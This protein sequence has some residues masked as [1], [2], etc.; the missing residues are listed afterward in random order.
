[1]QVST[2]WLALGGNKRGNWGEPRETFRRAL[3]ELGANGLDMVA[4][5]SLYLTPPVGNVRQS[6]F[7]NAVVEMRGSISPGSLLRLL[8]RLEREAGRRSGVRWGPRPLDLD[9]LDFGGRIV[10]R[11]SSRRAAGQILLPH[12]EMARRGFVLVPLAEIAPGWRHPLLG[13]PAATLL[14]RSPG[15]AKGIRLAAG[16]QWM[17]PRSGE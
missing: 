3:I 6:P 10:G 13:V 1:M 4:A 9:I 14:R 16:P 17:V 11:P 2:I 7:L 8:K 5:S 15:L 12:P